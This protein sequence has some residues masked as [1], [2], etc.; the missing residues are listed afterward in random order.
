MIGNP[1]LA[2]RRSFGRRI[3]AALSRLV[4]DRFQQNRPA[5]VES[6]R[7]FR[8]ELEKQFPEDLVHGE[9]LGAAP[10]ADHQ[11]WIIDPLDGSTNHRRGIPLFAI[12]IAYIEN[13]TPLLGWISDPVRGE[14]FEAHHRGGILRGGPG[15][16]YSGVA[17]PRVLC[18]SDRWIQ[19]FPRWIESIPEPVKVRSLGSIALEMAWIASGRIQG[20]AWYRTQPWDVAA[21]QLLIRESGGEVLT[22]SGAGPGAR[23]AVGAGV[24]SWIPRFKDG[25]PQYGMDARHLD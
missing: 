11:G 23:I 8:K 22:V 15:P 16:T 1:A 17:D 10:G 5:D 18:C 6:E 3:L 25:L 7:Y 13:G 19:K 14:W 12:S 21:G 20:G 9:E 4:R 2:R 24:Q